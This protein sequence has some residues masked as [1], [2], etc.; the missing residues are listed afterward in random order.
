MI[1]G[2]A[3]MMQPGMF[4][5]AVP[6]YYPVDG[7]IN[8]YINSRD[9]RPLRS[10]SRTVYFEKYVQEDEPENLKAGIE[11]KSLSKR[12]KKSH[13]V[14]NLSLKNRSWKNYIYVN[15]DW[16]VLT[17]IRNCNQ[18]MNQIR[19]SLGICPRQDVLYDELTV[20]DHLKFFCK[21]KGIQENQIVSKF[22]S[23]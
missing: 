16:I 22:S 15:A 14:K 2:S 20:E 10:S 17:N 12:F 18:E 11:I 13:A 5:V 23:F 6:W 21:V 1:I 3:L 4:G 7:I 9:A 19:N 8:L